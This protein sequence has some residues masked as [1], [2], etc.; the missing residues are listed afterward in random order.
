MRV[1]IYAAV[2][3]D[4]YIA[5]AAGGVGWLEG[6]DAASAGIDAFL[7]QVGTIVMG[8]ASFDQALGFPG[9]WPYAGKRVVVLTSRPL[10]GRVPEGVEAASGDPARLDLARGPGDVW[11]FGGARVFRDFLDAG[12]V[13][14]VELYVVPVLLG[15]G[16]PLLERRAG[17]PTSL[18]LVRTR[19]FPNGLV[20]LVYALDRP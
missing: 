15:D 8:R 16:I 14:S 5:D 7:A 11:L 18:R 20:E 9:P 6:F 19:P 17:R 3:A 10:P 4:G 12:R 2:S 1:R 13:D